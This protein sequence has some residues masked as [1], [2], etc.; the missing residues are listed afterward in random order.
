MSYLLPAQFASSALG[1][2]RNRFQSMR[3]PIPSFNSSMQRPMMQPSLISPMN[4][5][6]YMPN[7]YQQPKSKIL[8]A[9]MLLLFIVGIILSSIITAMPNKFMIG[10]K[11]SSEDEY[12]KRKNILLGLSWGITSFFAIASILSIVI[13]RKR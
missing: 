6:M 7:M 13:A 12:K 9:I 10:G 1:S 8:V 4:Q 3:S 11:I 2:I 5:P